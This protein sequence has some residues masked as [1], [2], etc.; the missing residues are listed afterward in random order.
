MSEPHTGNNAAGVMARSADAQPFVTM[1]AL[2]DEICGDLKRHANVA[3]NL[4]LLLI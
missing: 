2:L 3:Y 4:G 1:G